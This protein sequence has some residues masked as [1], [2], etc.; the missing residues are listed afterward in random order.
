MNA[1]GCHCSCSCPST[2]TGHFCQTSILPINRAYAGQM[3]VPVDRAGGNS[4]RKKNSF[5]S[6]VSDALGSS[7]ESVW[8]CLDQAWNHLNALL[9]N[10]FLKIVVHR[11]IGIKSFSMSHTLHPGRSY[12]LLPLLLSTDSEP[13][14][15]ISKPSD[16]GVSSTTGGARVV[17]IDQ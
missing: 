7:W 9:G 10:Y 8:P 16:G 3:V 12:D 15:P 13:G 6:S 4:I 2:F 5:L 11:V 14:T 17:S 1:T